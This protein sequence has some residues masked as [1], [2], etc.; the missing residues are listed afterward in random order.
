MNE[1]IHI[2]TPLPLAHVSFKRSSTKD[3][4]Q[5]YDIDVY[6]GCAEEEALRIYG[7]ALALKALADDALAPKPLLEQLEDSVAVLQREKA[8]GVKSETIDAVAGG[9]ASLSLKKPRDKAVDEALA[10][11]P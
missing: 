10:R 7:V 11:V 1:E 8:V 3:A 4:G 5:G 2:H 6:A 9:I